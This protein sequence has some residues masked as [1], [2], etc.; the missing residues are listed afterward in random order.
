MTMIKIH[1]AD[2]ALKHTTDLIKNSGC[3]ET[4]T[5]YNRFNISYW[6]QK[7]SS[8]L[9]NFKSIISNITAH[10]SDDCKDVILDSNNY[11]V[12]LS[13]DEDKNIGEGGMYHIGKSV[14]N[15]FNQLGN[16]STKAINFVV[17]IGDSVIQPNSIPNCDAYTINI[18]PFNNQNLIIWK[19]NSTASTSNCP[20]SNE[21]ENNQA[22]YGS[23]VMEEE[24]SM[25][26]FW[27][28]IGVGAC[29]AAAAVGSAYIYN[30]NY[31]H[32]NT[33]DN[34]CADT[35]MEEYHKVENVG[36][37]PTKYHDIV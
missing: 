14:L 10:L 19:F 5:N 12:R 36:E 17:D 26:N 1:C 21:Y 24:A 15:F 29:I 6:L 3:G 20:L 25:M 35:E 13:I 7:C 11:A 30:K 8:S 32:N 22:Q 33:E 2:N 37:S 9:N 18:I 34:S 28:M 31:Q 23:L 27:T 4:P 16:I